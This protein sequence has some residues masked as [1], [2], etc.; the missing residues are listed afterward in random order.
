[1]GTVLPSADRLSQFLDY[2]TAISKHD[3]GIPA[4]FTKFGIA[5]L[6]QA[7]RMR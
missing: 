2:L 3:A 4:E 1:M 7:W 5:T 6:L